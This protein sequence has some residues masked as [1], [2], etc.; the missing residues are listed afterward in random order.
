[1]LCWRRETRTVAFVTF[2][3][4]MIGLSGR[5]YLG[6][7]VGAMER[8]TTYPFP[9][10]LAWIGVAGHRIGKR[11]LCRGLGLWLQALRLA[12][13]D[14]L[15]ARRAQLQRIGLIAVA[16]PA[17]ERQSGLRF[18]LLRETSSNLLRRNL[19]RGA[20]LQVRRQNKAAIFA[21]RSVLKQ[22]GLVLGKLGG[23]VLAFRLDEGPANPGASLRRAP[24][25]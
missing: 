17:P 7:G 5:N 22:S 11:F 16:I 13:S 4:G 3:A 12:N 9:I 14:R 10:W 21:E 15:C 23:Q 8:I 24:D 6:I 1:M 25:D 19:L 2:I 20:A 18:D